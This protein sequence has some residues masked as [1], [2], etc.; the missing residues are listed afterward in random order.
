[1]TKTFFLL[2]FVLVLSSLLS[3][4][5][6]QGYRG[7]RRSTNEIARIYL[8]EKDN[9]SIQSCLIDDVEASTRS[10]I[11]ILPGRHLAE[12]RF[13]SQ[14]KKCSNAYALLDGLGLSGNCFYYGF[15]RARIET[16]GGRDYSLILSQLADTAH[17]GIVEYG[18]AI[19]AGSAHCVVTDSE[20]KLDQLSN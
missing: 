2:L 14:N 16:S 20:F 3:C 17:L 1:M 4:S 19:P 7:N 13:T 12:V 5:L 9:I 10:G 11:E 8:E 6:T 18:T 15:C